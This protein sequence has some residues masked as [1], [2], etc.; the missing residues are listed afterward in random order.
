LEI[1][2]IETNEDEINQTQKNNED[3]DYNNNDNNMKIK[4]WGKL[5]SLQ[6]T[7]GHVDLVNDELTI[8]R[9]K[10]CSITFSDVKISGIH[11]KIFRK[12]TKLPSSNRSINSYHSIQDSPFTTQIFLE[13]FS[14]NGTFINGKKLGKGNKTLLNNG[15]EISLVSISGN[16]NCVASYIFHDLSIIDQ[17]N[18]QYDKEI[19][20]NYL[21]DKIIGTGNFSTVRL[22]IDKNSG[23][24]KAIKIIDKKKYWN[25]NME[26]LER[27]IEIVKQ[28]KHENIISVFDIYS[29]QKFLYIVLEFA[30]G[31]ELFEHI[32]EQGSYSESEARLLFIQILKG[33]SYL[34]KHGIV[35]RDLKP[36]NILLEIEDGIKVKISDFGLA[37][38]VGEREMMTTLCGTPLYVA[39]EIIRGTFDSQYK[40]KGYGKEV[41]VWSLGVILYVLLS[42]VP[43]FDEEKKPIPLYEQIQNGLYEFP[44]DFWSDISQ[45][46]I[47]LIKKF[48]TVDPKKR[49]CIEEAFQHPWIT[50]NISNLSH[51]ELSSVTKNLKKNK[52]IKGIP[53]SPIKIPH[54]HAN[55]DTE[56]E[57]EN[58]YKEKKRKFI[59]NENLTLKKKINK[60]LFNSQ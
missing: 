46:A 24:K 48:L 44:L 59:E 37:K 15:D 30:N 58:L 36:E 21:I 45:Q 27:E 13:D 22:A 17:I 60:K 26:Q 43:P 5:L 28:I 54:N 18:N 19:T 40:E 23:E 50:G 1:K 42:G 9:R 56:D 52:Q 8:G 3:E 47:D 33:V 7:N 49:I 20:K 6:S 35:H 25:K 4:I 34:H 57:K 41:D 16:K 11:C 38:I 32:I 31:G 51:K 2:N 12:V 14:L 39:P 29:T 53:V 55:S 10:E